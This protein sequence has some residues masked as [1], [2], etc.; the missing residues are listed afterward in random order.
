[1][2]YIFYVNLSVKIFNLKM[3][4][5]SGREKK[6]EEKIFTLF[7]HKIWHKLVQVNMIRDKL[8]KMNLKI[9]KKI[10]Y[11][12]GSVMI[13]NFDSSSSFKYPI[14]LQSSAQAF[15]GFKFFVSQFGV[16]IDE[17]TDPD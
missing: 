4:H 7:R 13:M 17:F 11:W 5:G 10:I 9:E 16:V 2:I 15:A 14:S 8:K 6:K 1:M 3:N 12:T